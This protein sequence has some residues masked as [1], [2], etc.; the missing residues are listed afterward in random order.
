MPRV[1]A[2]AP[3]RR[4]VTTVE[5]GRRETGRGRGVRTALYAAAWLPYL[6]VYF[7][8]FLASGTIAPGFALRA[9]LANVLPDILLA[10]LVLRLPR[11]FPWP[12]ARRGGF[13]ALHAGLA[14]AFAVLA[15]AG[16]LV[17]FTFD[18]LLFEGVLA[19]PRVDLRVVPFQA[20]VSVLIYLVLAGMSYALGNAERVRAE[21]ERAAR[22]EAL[23]AQAELAALR[24][25][26]NPHFL[27]NT[28]H[29]VIGL[30]V[31]D[32]PTAQAA[33]ERLGDMLRYALRIHRDGVD[34]VG[35][36][37][38]WEFVAT[39]L[40]L[41]KLRLGDRLR[42][43]LDADP[44][45]FDSLVPPFCLQPLVENAVRHAVAP[46]AGGGRI[47]VAARR[48]SE[49]LRL[50][51]QDDGPGLPKVPT[52]DAGIGLR[53]VQDRLTSLYGGKARF[54]TE[55]PADGGL[56]VTL[57]LPASGPDDDRE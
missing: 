20:F 29:S 56:R 31:Q 54:E 5:S 48:T 24:A 17:L 15:T 47:V 28:L 10:P 33:L 23:R 40:D 41:E 55:S 18:R 9:A 35:L 12:Q 44:D 46:R 26:L 51:V 37:E 52:P 32:P 7:V 49:T 14:A 4:E 36:R 13:L 21:S 8:A 39:Y 25:Q 57:T 34:A 3:L 30:V 19:A 27:F 38:E 42:L 50:T 2:R 16:K 6:A 1:R 22:A 45:V 43:A 53:L 11:R